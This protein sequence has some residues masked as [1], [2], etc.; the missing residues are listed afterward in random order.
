M[1]F[2]RSLYY[3]GSGVDAVP[4]GVIAVDLEGTEDLTSDVRRVGLE[5]TSLGMFDDSAYQ[6]QA[7]GDEQDLLV[8]LVPHEK[9]KEIGMYLTSDQIIPD[10]Q[11][12][13]LKKQDGLIISEHALSDMDCCNCCADD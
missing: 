11:F 2:I 6:V 8:K 3:W 10:Y 1:Y 4:R 13:L 12:E 7:T 9:Y 5:L